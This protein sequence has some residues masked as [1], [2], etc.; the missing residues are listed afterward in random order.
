MCD[1]AGQYQVLHVVSSTSY[2]THKLEHLTGAL[3]PQILRIERLHFL[4][5]SQ[6]TEEILAIFALWFTL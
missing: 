4:F 1:R 2:N 6:L 5:S 3:E